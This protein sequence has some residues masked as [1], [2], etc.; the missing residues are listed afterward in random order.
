[1]TVG[2]TLFFLLFLT[3]LKQWFEVIASSPSCLFLCNHF[4]PFLA[5]VSS[6]FYLV[7]LYIVSLLIWKSNFPGPPAKS[8]QTC[9][10]P[11]SHNTHSQ[12]LIPGPPEVPQ[13]FSSSTLGAESLWQEGAEASRKDR[14]K[15]NSRELVAFETWGQGPS[16]RTKR[17][18]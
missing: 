13:S 6:L 18:P 4:F 10:C 1:M 8:L 7:L 15:E 14:P 16:L 17:C 3:L 11:Q 12:L 5:S 9:Q 2:S